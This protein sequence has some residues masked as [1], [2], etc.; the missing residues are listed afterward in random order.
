MGGSWSCAVPRHVWTFCH[1][2]PGLLHLLLCWRVN[3]KFLKQCITSLHKATF[4]VTIKLNVLS[5]LLF[6][7]FAVTLLYGKINSEKHLE[8][9]EHSYLPPTQT[10]VLKVRTHN[11]VTVHLWHKLVNNILIQFLMR[12]IVMRIVAFVFS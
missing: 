8:M 12:S 10:G 7:G 6:R 1:I 5:F 11:A 4:T 3:N 2:L 9:S